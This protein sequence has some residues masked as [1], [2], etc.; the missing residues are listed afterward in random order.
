[1]RCL[2][3]MFAEDVGLLPGDSFTDLLEGVR[4]A[5]AHF[6]PLI[7]DLWRA[8]GRGG[9][10]PAIRAGRPWSTSQGCSWPGSKRCELP[11]RRAHGRPR[12]C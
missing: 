8:M 9:F 7:T 2:F 5:P 3:S 1:M 12:A 4:E 11:D 6:V 10:C